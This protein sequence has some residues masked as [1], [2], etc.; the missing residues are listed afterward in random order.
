MERFRGRFGQAET[1]GFDVNGFLEGFGYQN[2]DEFMA[3]FQ[4]MIENAKETEDIDDLG[5]IGRI[6]RGMDQNLNQEMGHHRAQYG[7][8]G[9]S[10]GFGQEQNG[11]GFGQESSGSGYGQEGSGSGY[12]VSGGSGQMGFGGGH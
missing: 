3:R 6:I 2:E 11:S 9:S 7:Q 10:G 12:G 5:E 8:T 1:E 4:E